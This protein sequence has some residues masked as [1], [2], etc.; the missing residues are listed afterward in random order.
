MIAIAHST[1]RPKMRSSRLRSDRIRTRL[2]LVAEAVA[3]AAHREDVLRLLGVRLELLAQVAD[4]DVDGARVAIG[5]VA[6]HAREE[7]GA[8]EHAARARGERAQDLELHE[9]G[10]HGRA[11]Q[12]HRALGGVDAQVAHLERAVAVVAGPRHPGAPQ[13]GL[14]PRA[15]LAHGERLGDVVVGAQLEPD[16]LVDLL[17]LRGQHDDRHARAS[18]Q[19]PAHLEPV[20]VGEHEVEH[21][22]VERLLGEARER[23]LPVRR[24]DHLLVVAL[25]GGGQQRLDRH[26]VVDEQD[27]RSAV[28]HGQDS[29]G[30]DGYPR[31]VPDVRV[32]RAAFAPALVALFVAAFS[33]ADRPAGVTTPF[34]PAGFVGSRAYDTLERLGK[35]FPERPPGSDADRALA[36]RVARTFRASGFRVSRN[37]HSARTPDGPAELETVVGVRPGLSSRRIVVMAHRDARGSPALAELSGTAALLELARLFKVRDLS[38]TLVLVSTSGGSAGGAGARGFAGSGAGPV[39]P[40]LVLG[41]G[42]GSRGRKPWIVPWSNDRDAAPMGIVRTLERAVRQEVGAQAGGSRAVGQWARR[43][44]PLT[45]SEQGEAARAGLPAVLLQV[46]GERGP[47][48]RTPVSEDRLDS[49]G[50]ATL[51]AITALDTRV[52]R[53][54][55]AGPFA[56][57]G[58]GIV[59]FR[60]LLPDWAIRLLVGTLLLPAALTAVDAFFG[61]RR[62]R[63]PVARWLGWVAAAAVPFALA[64]L[65]MRLVALTGAMSVPAGPVL[66]DALPLRGWRI[67]VGLSAPAVLALAWVAARR[68][69]VA[70]LH[71]PATVSAG[72][73]AAALGLVIN[74]LA[75][76]V[77]VVNPLAAALL[78]PAAH[79]W[80]FATAPGT[81]TSGRVRV[82]LVLAGLAL[83]AIMA[84]HYALALDLGVLDLMWLAVLVTAGGHISLLAALVLSGL[85][86]CLCGVVAVVR[87][88]RRVVREA[89]PEAITTR[90]PLGYAGPGSLGGTESALRR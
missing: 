22:E 74:A 6:P 62:R 54:D 88:R 34:A 83:P 44:L 78:V 31:P 2:L 15:E 27:A 4:V 63:L 1:M 52:A 33:L 14:D 26:L 53:S 80:L 38:S 85:A 7:H 47:S 50:R 29:V 41:D 79:G 64:W 90:G 36:G 8:R 75:V 70:R 81:A 25:Q 68:P 71:L 20:D 66:P 43:A 84:V 30:P 9:R 86:G 76:V 32:Y 57:E 5:R 67:A 10:R 77:W 28:G 3:D 49:F 87:T 21:H 73:A 51:R 89:E 37:T 18:A 24:R 60:R 11:M 55:E 12:G 40:P 16:H 19:P 39:D 45:V 46:S 58:G 23:L 72:G 17:R 61:A 42:A 13:R 56:D 65:W 59:T 35:A 82:A 48:P 69:L